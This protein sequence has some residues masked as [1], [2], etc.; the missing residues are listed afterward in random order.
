MLDWNGSDVGHQVPWNSLD[1]GPADGRVYAAR[2]GR[3]YVS[4]FNELIQVVHG[5]GY[6]TTYL[7]LEPTSYSNYEWTICISRHVARKHNSA[8][9]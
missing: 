7:H 9:F 5:D 2:G 4:C 8:R 1:F 6:V 3:A